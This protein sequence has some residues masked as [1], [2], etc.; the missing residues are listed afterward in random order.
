MN[1]T[2]YS[3]LIEQARVV[4]AARKVAEKF[5]LT[6]RVIS[7]ATGHPL[8][9]PKLVVGLMMA[10]REIN[11]HTPIDFDKL[12]AMKPAPMN[13]SINDAMGH[14]TIDGTFTGDYRPEWLL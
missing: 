8:N 14:L 5:A 4:I 7:Y 2:D 11:K 3:E 10:L 12:E 9:D 13:E 1:P 6:A